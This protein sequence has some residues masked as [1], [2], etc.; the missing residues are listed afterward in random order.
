MNRELAEAMA[1]NEGSK[2]LAAY[3]EEQLQ[4]QLQAIREQE[5]SLKSTLNVK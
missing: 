1:N 4:K 2:E 3:R 5:E